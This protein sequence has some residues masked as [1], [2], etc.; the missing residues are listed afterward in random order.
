VKA[1]AVDLR[2]QV[3]ERTIARGWDDPVFAEKREP[4]I[5]RL[6]LRRGVG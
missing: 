2:E 6:L 1:L 4:A 3:L 5:W